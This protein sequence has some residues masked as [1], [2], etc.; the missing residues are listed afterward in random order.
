[1]NQQTIFQDA[2][3]KVKGRHLDSPTHYAWAAGFLE[4]VIRAVCSCSEVGEPPTQNAPEPLPQTTLKNPRGTGGH[5]VHVT[6]EGDGKELEQE[7]A[8]VDNSHP[9]QLEE[10]DEPFSRIL[11]PK[12]GTGDELNELC[13]GC[14]KRYVNIA[15][16]VQHRIED[17]PERI[18]LPSRGP[19]AFRR[20]VK[21]VLETI[22]TMARVSYERI[23]AT[24]KR[25]QETGKSRM[26]ETGVIES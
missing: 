22:P 19:T 15:T 4:G 9:S 12:P 14:N 17:C 7:Q 8:F 13:P 3:E 18:N 11:N 26:R 2:L 25:L 23:L 1:M 10:K 20:V 24:Y 6:V 21:T 5:K 16:L